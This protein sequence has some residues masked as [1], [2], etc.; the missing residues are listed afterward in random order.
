[1]VT[2]A[3]AASAGAALS[4]AADGT[5]KVLATQLFIKKPI[6]DSVEGSDGIVSA[7]TVTGD[8]GVLIP[9]VPL[10][11]QERNNIPQQ[12]ATNRLR[13]CMKRMRFYY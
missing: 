7:V 1:M 11:L 5:V 3:S 2:V 10:F 9:P 13:G 12:A 6:D 4:V 8:T